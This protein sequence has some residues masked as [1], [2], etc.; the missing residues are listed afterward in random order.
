MK[1][2]SYFKQAELMLRAIPHVAAE[3]CFALKDRDEDSNYRKNRVIAKW[4]GV[5]PVRRVQLTRFVKLC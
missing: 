2:S 1:D 5:F 3:T 4:D